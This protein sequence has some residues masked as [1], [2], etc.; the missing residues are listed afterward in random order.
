MSDSP[1]DFSDLELDERDLLL[2][3]EDIERPPSCGAPVYGS[4]AYCT[5]YKRSPDNVAHSHSGTVVCDCDIVAALVLNRK[6]ELNIV[7]YDDARLLLKYLDDLFHCRLRNVDEA[8]D[9]TSIAIDDPTPL[10]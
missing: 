7:L 2:L 4:E 1:D 5:S 3:D 9:R 8:C 6:W 10:E